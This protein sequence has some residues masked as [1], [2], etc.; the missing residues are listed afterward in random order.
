[1]EALQGR[2][3]SGAGRTNN[4]AGPPLSSGGSAEPWIVMSRR[5]VRKPAN[6]GGKAMT[7][8]SRRQ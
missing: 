6:Q 7:P 4:T 8:Q 2:V 1:M 3:L 5:L